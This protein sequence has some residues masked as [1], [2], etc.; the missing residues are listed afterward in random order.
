MNN[1]RLPAEWEPQS[2][3]ILVW[4]QALGDWKHNLIEVEKSYL[5]IAAEICAQ[6]TLVVVCADEAH[7]AYIEQQLELHLTP[8]GID[9]N[10]PQF[11]IAVSNDSWVRDTAPFSIIEDRDDNGEIKEHL[12]LLNFT[13]NGW[14]DKYPSAL[15]NAITQHLTA[16]RIFGQHPVVNHPMILEGGSIESDG[17]GTLLTTTSCLANPNRNPELSIEDIEKILRT[18]LGAKRI[19]WLNHG[20]LIGDDTDGHIDTLARFCSHDT[21]AYTHCNDQSDI[22]YAPLAAMASELA[23]LKTADGKPYRLLPL[24]IPA[25]IYNLEG[26]RLPANYANFLIINNAVLVPTYNDPNDALALQTLE[27]C[28]PDRKVIGINCHSL[29][30]QF[31]SLHCATMQFPRGALSSLSTSEMKP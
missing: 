12:Y 8:K 5:S 20:Q 25:A 26:D 28:F 9:S 23:A 17:Q 27:G 3:V 13:F 19:L 22:Q 18:E 15:D 24:P 21:I 7:R 31:G 2:G 6:E 14:G 1:R 4:P 11:I 10:N 29:L 16:G 30:Q